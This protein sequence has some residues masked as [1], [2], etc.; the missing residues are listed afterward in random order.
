M[1]GQQ[2]TI[3]AGDAFTLLNT[4]SE[5]RNATNELRWHG[6]TIETRGRGKMHFYRQNDGRAYL[7]AKLTAPG[8]MSFRLYVLKGGKVNVSALAT[9]LPVM[10][11]PRPK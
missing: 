5:R 4:P 2:L 1:K 10:A 11:S 8:R 9:V 3:D 6:C 7:V